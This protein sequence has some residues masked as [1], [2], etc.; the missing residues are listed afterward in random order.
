KLAV[1]DT[2]LT[3]M[4]RIEST[5]RH[6]D[7]ST[8]I[9]PVV[10]S[11]LPGQSGAN[12]AGVFASVGRIPGIEIQTVSNTVAGPADVVI[13]SGI[14]NDVSRKRG[15]ALKEMVPTP[16]SPESRSVGMNNAG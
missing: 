13:R 16:V 5:G 4:S 8:M 10:V 6:R 1:S 14:R 15:A 9:E 12:E 3:G 2:V 11:K 7:P